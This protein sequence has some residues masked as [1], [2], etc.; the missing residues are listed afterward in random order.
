MTI[1][2]LSRHDIMGLLMRNLKL[3][4]TLHEIVDVDSNGIV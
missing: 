4:S 2:C 1:G 3:E